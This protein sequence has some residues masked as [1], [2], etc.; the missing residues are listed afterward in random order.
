MERHPGTTY[1]VIIDTFMRKTGPDSLVRLGRLTKGRGI[2]MQ[3]AGAVPT[4]E[5]QKDILPKLQQTLASLR[6]D[7]VDIW[8]GYAH[9][10]P[11]STLSLIKSL[12]FAQSN[13]YVWHE[14][15][16]AETHEGEGEAVGRS[17]VAGAGARELGHD[18]VAA[19]ADEQ[20]AGSQPVRF[21][22]RRR[23]GR[24][25]GQ[26]FR[27]QPGPATVRTRWRSGSWENGTKST[28]H[29]APFP[30]DEALTIQL[31]RDEK[32][33]GNISDAGAHLQMLC[34]GGENILLFTKY[35]KEGLLTMEEAIHVKTGKLANF[36]GLR[37]TG[38]L[39]VGK[40]ADIVVF[41]IDEIA[42]RDME[43]RF[44]VPDGEGGTTW[45][46][47]RQAAPMR[48]TLVNGIATFD[49]TAY[50]GATPGEYISP[51]A[52]QDA[53]RVLQAAE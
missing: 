34:G 43:K 41:D 22:E 19:F 18:G 50:T 27:R 10:S 44:D 33:V 53:A 9:V 3:V 39:K 28:V 20:P 45:R 7:G 17:R 51:Q 5:F 26:G 13:D 4:L 30:K 31:M 25:D 32:S 2:R 14:V 49:G 11:T 12:I 1:Q 16:L 47:T 8:P 35:V 38:E 21:G 29:M 36:F 24:T 37:E 6:E 52:G 48:L 23:P 40:R 42:Y 46:F 15:V